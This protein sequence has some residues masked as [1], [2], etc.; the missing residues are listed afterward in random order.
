M[1]VSPSKPK[2]L[3]PSEG[4]CCESGSCTPCIWDNYYAE[5]KIWRLEQVK[6]KEQAVKNRQDNGNNE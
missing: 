2:P 6:I 3:P 5:L 4:E 1:P